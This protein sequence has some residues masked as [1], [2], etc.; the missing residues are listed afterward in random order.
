MSTKITYAALASLGALVFGIFACSEDGEETTSPNGGPG[1]G[2]TS[3]T[4][5]QA[6]ADAS[7]GVAVGGN[8]S[9]QGGSCADVVVEAST[10]KN[11]ADIIFMVDNSG[12]MTDENAA[13]EQNINVNFAAIMGS[14]GVDYQV[15]MITD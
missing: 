11:P 9:G 4:S 8:S 14:S 12:S 3:T 10:V 6:S 7:V 2:A 13:I 15:I 5:Q 1:S